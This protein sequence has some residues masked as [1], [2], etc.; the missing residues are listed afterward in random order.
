[1][2]CK[3]DSTENLRS[4]EKYPT[5]PLLWTKLLSDFTNLSEP[6]SISAGFQ[7]SGSI[8]AGFNVFLRYRT[9]CQMRLWKPARATT[10][11]TALSLFFIFQSPPAPLIALSSAMIKSLCWQ[12]L[13]NYYSIAPVKRYGSPFHGTIS[14]STAALVIQRRHHQNPR[15][16][17]DQSMADT[18][19]QGDWQI[20]A[21]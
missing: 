11:F 16:C 21:L 2:S 19:T 3:L 7:W 13:C 17:T 14:Q 8:P 20:G 9:R 5:Q 1:M 4:F 15:P 18:H 10:R 6:G 12:P